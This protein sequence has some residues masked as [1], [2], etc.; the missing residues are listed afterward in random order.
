MKHAIRAGAEE[1][2][3]AQDYDYGYR[4]ATIKDPFGHYW[5]LQRKI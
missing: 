2:S 5:Q 4:Q 3:P 1:I